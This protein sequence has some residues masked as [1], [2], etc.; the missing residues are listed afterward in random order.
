MKMIATLGQRFERSL[1]SQMAVLLIVSVLFWAFGVPTWIKPAQA[2]YLTEISDTLSSSENS[3]LAEHAI[4]WTTSTS[5][6]ATDQIKIQLDPSTNAF[7]QSFSTATST[8]IMM[9][10]DGTAIE[11]VNA[12]DCAA[13]KV[14]AIG[15]YNN[16]SDENLTLT[17]CSGTTIAADSDILLDVGS[18][19][20]LW[21]NPGSYGS[22]VI[23]VSA[24]GSKSTSGETQVAIISRVTLTAAVSSTFTFEINGVNG[25]TSVN[26]TTTTAA[27]NTTATTLP[28]GTLSPGVPKFLAQRLNVTTNATNGFVV[29]VQ[30]DQPP[31]TAAGA[32]IYLFSN[33]ASTTAPIAWAPPTG[34]VNAFQTYAHIGITSDDQDLSTNTGSANDDFTST[35]FAGDLFQPRAVFAHNGPSDGLVA[36]QGSTTVG[37][38]IQTTSLL[39]AGDYTNQ[40]TYVATPTF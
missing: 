5:T 9:Y 34:T 36:N 10:D 27:I 1:P 26:G 31:T 25:G 17:L 2:A 38:E 11:V 21:T 20:K 7:S 14:S 39:P 13:G 37:Y 29:T 32:V 6:V 16:G 4:R 23:E 33:G 22:Y 30:E 40:I 3:T 19:T 28:F 24:S 35:K 8:E 15:N 12:A 18:T